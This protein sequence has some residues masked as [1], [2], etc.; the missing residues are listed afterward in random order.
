MLDAL[1]Q[2]LVPSAIVFGVTGIVVVAIVLAIRTI[3][4][5]SRARAAAEAS[6]S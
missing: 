4:R 1:L 6:P 3:R 2:V 5:G